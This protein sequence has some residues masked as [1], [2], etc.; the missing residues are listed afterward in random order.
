MLS[1]AVRKITIGK[2]KA[3]RTNTFLFYYARKQELL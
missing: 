2:Q 1:A 3:N